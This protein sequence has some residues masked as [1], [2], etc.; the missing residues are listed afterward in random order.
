MAERIEATV[1]EAQADSEGLVEAVLH[2]ARVVITRDGEAVAEL[3][4]VREV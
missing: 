4:P 3:E 1:E 2:G